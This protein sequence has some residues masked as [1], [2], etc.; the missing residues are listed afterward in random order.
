M[1]HLYEIISFFQISVERNLNCWSVS[2]AW[3]RKYGTLGYSKV[4]L[5]PMNFS[6]KWIGLVLVNF[7]W[8]NKATP[9]NSWGGCSITSIKILVEQGGK[10]PVGFP[11][12][13]YLKV[14]NIVLGIIFT[15]FQ[16]ELRLET[17]QVLVRP[18]SGP[19]EK[20]KFDIDRGM[21]SKETS[22]CSG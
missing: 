20:P 22:R 15:T 16:G 5:V 14:L 17:Q 6:R 9:S 4:K 11:V 13:C 7:V 19:N 2:R 1:C 12:S 8:S 10:I 3:R 18:D 21:S